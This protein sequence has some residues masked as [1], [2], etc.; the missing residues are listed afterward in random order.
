MLE[1]SNNFSFFSFDD[2]WRYAEDQ[3]KSPSTHLMMKQL[4]ADNINKH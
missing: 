3:N 4:A 1:S 2:T